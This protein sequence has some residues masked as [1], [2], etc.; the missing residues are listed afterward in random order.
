MKMKK[1]LRSKDDQS[2]HTPYLNKPNEKLVRDN[3]PEIIKRSGKT[4]V[5]KAETNN[6]KFRQHLFDKIIEELNEFKEE[7][8][9]EEAADILEVFHALLKF[10]KINFDLVKE[11]RLKKGLLRGGFDKRLIL[12]Q[13]SKLK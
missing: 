11:V 12:R 7:P 2:F 1:N 10:E 5:V 8:S 4:A 6:T 9:A 13:T 3:I